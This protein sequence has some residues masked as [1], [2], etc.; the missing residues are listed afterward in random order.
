MKK[1]LLLLATTLALSAAETLSDLTLEQALELALKN[2]PSLAEAHAQ[3]DL[4]GART[5]SAGKLPNPEAIARLESAPFSSPTARAEYVAGLSQTIPLGGRLSAARQAEQAAQLTRSR[6]LDAAKFEL[7]R[8]V[9]NAFATALFSSEVLTL[10]TNQAAS[11]NELLRITQ[12]RADLGDLSPI[13]LARLESTAAQHQLE[14]HEARRLHHAALD[15]LATEMGDFRIR[16]AS[17]TGSLEVVLQLDAIRAETFGLAHP[18]IQT[19]ESDV[20]THAARLKLARAE[21]IPDLNLDLLYRRLESSR[22]NAFD[23]GVRLPIPLFDRQKRSRQAEHELRASE[24]RLASVR[25]HVGHEQHELEVDLRAALDAADL[26]KTRVLPPSEKALQAAEARY[27][28]G[29]LSLSELLPIRRDH[30]ALQLRY[31]D[32]LRTIMTA[33][34]GLRLTHPPIP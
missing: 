9:H 25:N 27:R 6:E 16:I 4:A 21:R 3:L 5:Q 13:D 20:K 26:L 14:L 22:E 8:K 1:L 18:A 30:A 10:Q 28:A 24:A 31:A 32:A 12:A 7:T 29:D 19:A 2:H 11:L 33:R 17:L 23:V 34:A 15:A